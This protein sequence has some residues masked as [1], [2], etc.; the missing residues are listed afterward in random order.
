MARI[1]KQ[2][3]PE[4]D[5]QARLVTDYTDEGAVL[6]IRNQR[7]AL[8]IQLTN[9]QLRDLKWALATHDHDVHDN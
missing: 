5:G 3:I 8:S 7:R 1:S 9:D 2:E 6:T 4:L